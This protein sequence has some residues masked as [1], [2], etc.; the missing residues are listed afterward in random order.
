M[1]RNNELGKYEI[2]ERGVQQ[3]YV[4]SPDILTFTARCFKKGLKVCIIG[5]HN[6]DDMGSADNTTLIEDSERKLKEV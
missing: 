2:I 3:G 4:F 5:G 6:L 1:Q